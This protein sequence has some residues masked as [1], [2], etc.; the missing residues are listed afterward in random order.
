VKGNVE[1]PG[2]IDG[3]VYIPMD[4]RGAWK[5]DLARNMES[6]GFEIDYKKMCN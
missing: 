6:A 4:E 1:T 5:I 2:D 3:V